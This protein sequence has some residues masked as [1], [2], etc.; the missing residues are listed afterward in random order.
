MDSAC[1]GLLPSSPDP[2]PDV[3]TILKTNLSSVFLPSAS[4][5]NV[6]FSTPKPFGQDWTTCIRATVNGAT[7]GSIGMQTYLL[8]ISRGAVSRQQN[9]G[10]SHWC[11]SESFEP[12]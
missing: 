11:S 3:R 2:T 4:P 7:G 12:I 6:S 9:V 1:A 5:T 10:A 8:N